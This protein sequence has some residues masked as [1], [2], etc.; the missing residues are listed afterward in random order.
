MSDQQMIVTMFALM[1]LFA[2]KYLLI[3]GLVIR[4]YVFRSKSSPDDT[5]DDDDDDEGGNPGGFRFPTF[6]PPGGR[7]LDDLLVDRAPNDYASPVNT[8]E[9]MTI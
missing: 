8:P 1:L 6:D 7:S 4:L 9:R 2:I 5:D 3:V